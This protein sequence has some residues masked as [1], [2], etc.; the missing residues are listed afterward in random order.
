MANNA[1]RFSSKLNF[2]LFWNIAADFLQFI[3][4]SACLG[5]EKNIIVSKQDAPKLALLTF[6]AFGFLP[7]NFS[8]QIIQLAKNHLATDKGLMG[9]NCAVSFVYKYEMKVKFT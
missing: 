6:N 1:R 9:K 8:G 4:N 7:V 3:T 5:I 2:P